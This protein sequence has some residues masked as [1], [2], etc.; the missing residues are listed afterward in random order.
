MQVDW[1]QKWMAFQHKGSMVT[2]QGLAPD[3]YALTVPS[4]YL[5]LPTTEASK[6]PDEIKQVL[7]KYA[8]VFAPPKG[9]PPRR[10]FDHTIP[11]IPGASPV[12]K[13]PYRIPPHLKDELEKQIAEMLE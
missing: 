2:L 10:Q 1:H 4:I 8:K 5:E 3:E 13:R 12:A 11:L 9:L 7:D 6:L